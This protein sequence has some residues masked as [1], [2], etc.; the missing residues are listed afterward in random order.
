MKRKTLTIED[1]IHPGEKLD[2]VRGLLDKLSGID[3]LVVVSRAA[4][5][6]LAVEYAGMADE[7]TAVGMLAAGMGI[8]LQ[9]EDEG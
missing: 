9:A 4:D 2:L 6:G 7:L 5:G 3:C 8:L 1:I